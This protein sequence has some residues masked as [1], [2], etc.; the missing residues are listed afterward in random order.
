MSV[1]GGPVPA[2]VGQ[3]YHRARHKRMAS[4]ALN[5]AAAAFE[6]LGIP[7]WAEQAREEAGRVGLH[8]KTSVPTA[9]GT[10]SCR[11]RCVR[12]LEPE[13]AAELFHVRQDRRSQPDPDLPKVSVRSRTELANRLNKP[14]SATSDD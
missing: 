4:D 1:R 3:A 12:T 5:E 9:D 8:H 10:P 14:G 11:I 6:T 2:C 13:T 7:R